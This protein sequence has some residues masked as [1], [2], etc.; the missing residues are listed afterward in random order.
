MRW[1]ETGGF[2]RLGYPVA[3]RNPLRRIGPGLAIAA[4]GV[5]AGDLLAAM[6]AGADFGT[7]L[8]WAVVVGAALKLALN[9]GLARWQL[10]T[11]T[12]LVEGW[13]RHLGRPL[14]AALLLY[15]VV[16]S[17]IVAAGLMSACGIAAHAVVPALSI[18]AWAALHSLAAVV[19]VLAGRYAL[20]EAVMKVMVGLMT[21]TLLVSVVLVGVPAGGALSGLLLPRIPAGSAGALLGLM[22]G[23]GGSVTMLA[24]G[25][26]I[27]ERGWVGRDQL[28]RVRVDLAVGYGLTA[29]F[30]VA[31]L[32]LAATVLGAAGE[33]MPPGSGALVALADAVRAGAAARLGATAGTVAGGVFLAGVWAAVA[34]STLGVWQGVPYLFSDFLRALRG[35]AEST[36]STSSA[37]Y[38]GYLLYLALPPMVLLVAERP[39]WLVRMYTVTSGLF[40][41]LLAASLL[42]LVSRRRLV[43]DLRSGRLATSMLL[44]AL[45]LFAAI[46]LR[47]VVD[48][49]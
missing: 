18:S 36:V 10:A 28:H 29:L 27:R 14:L 34:T 20:F 24:Y 30:G 26:W 1:V 16:W 11:G 39:V 47:T 19:L 35:A 42:W 7:A 4:T 44:L 17:F 2:L 45:L 5:G 31:V 12:T 8:A 9:E 15:L 13:C 46:L 6:V 41:P 25:Y 23:V 40:M 49:A 22:G 21:V 32:L 33:G 48:L 3:V 43:G 38:R 37:L